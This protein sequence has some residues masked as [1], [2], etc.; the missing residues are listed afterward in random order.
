MKAPMGTEV[1]SACIHQSSANGR[2]EAQERTART[3]RDVS[4]LRARSVADIEKSR[5]APSIT[6]RCIQFHRIGHMPSAFHETA[7]RQYECVRVTPEPVFGDGFCSRVHTYYCVR[8]AS[9]I[10]VMV[11][12]ATQFKRW[13]PAGACNSVSLSVE[14]PKDIPGQENEVIE[15]RIRLPWGLNPYRNPSYA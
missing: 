2:P 9:G 8:Q 13:L 11:G 1:V 7:G 5:S 12:S 3:M 15:G 4:R 6:Q 14:P 10:D